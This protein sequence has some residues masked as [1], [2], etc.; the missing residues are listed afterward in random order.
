MIS[1]ENN[2][3]LKKISH[4]FSYIGSDEVRANFHTHV[5]TYLY[6]YGYLTYLR[7]TFQNKELTLGMSLVG[8]SISSASSG[9]REQD[10]HWIG[11]ARC[12]GYVWSSSRSPPE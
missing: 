2:C 3:L 4:H 7:E 12:S 8:L 1:Q 11:E 5:F 6:M 9:V 10:S